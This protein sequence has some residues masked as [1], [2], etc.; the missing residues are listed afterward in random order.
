MLLMGMFHPLNS[1]LVT[2]NWRLILLRK[3]IFF[4]ILVT[5]GPISLTFLC[6]AFLKLFCAQLITTCKQQPA[7]LSVTWE[8]HNQHNFHSEKHGEFCLKNQQLF[9]SFAQKTMHK[10]VD[11]IY[12]WQQK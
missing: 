11:E 6:P 5:L 7:Q 1:L 12:A 2:R 8:W 3:Y 9:L 10:H 4:L